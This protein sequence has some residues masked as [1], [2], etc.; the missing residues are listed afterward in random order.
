MT[1][2]RRY[3][4]VPAKVVV[5]AMASK[6]PADGGQYPALA[7]MLEDASGLPAVAAA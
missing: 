6:L 2:V 7:V 3:G 1:T 4:P 5:Q